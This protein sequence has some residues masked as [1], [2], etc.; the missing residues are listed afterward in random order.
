MIVHTGLTRFLKILVDI[1]DLLKMPLFTQETQKL[2]SIFED[3]KKFSEILRAGQED[4]L[5]PKYPEK[6]RNISIV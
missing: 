2:A 5:L 3:Q 6:V 1:K 4:S